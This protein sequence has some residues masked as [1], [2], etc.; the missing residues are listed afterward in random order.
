MRVK[1]DWQQRLSSIGE[2]S[3]SAALLLAI[4]DV[5]ARRAASVLDDTDASH[6]TLLIAHETS[7]RRDVDDRE[8]RRPYGTSNRRRGGS[9]HHWSGPELSCHKHEIRS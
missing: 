4:V 2:H 5:Q 7:A 3:A 6:R 8:R 1:Q 9:P